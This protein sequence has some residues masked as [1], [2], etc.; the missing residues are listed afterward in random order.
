MEEGG[1]RIRPKQVPASLGH[2][3]QLAANMWVTVDEL[4][5]L[6]H[7]TPQAV[8]PTEA[9]TPESVIRQ[10]RKLYA[11]G[12]SV[13]QIKTILEES[14]ATPDQ[15]EAALAEVRQ[16]DRRKR[17]S[18]QRSL[19]LMGSAGA[20]F[21]LLLAGVAAVVVLRP[22]LRPSPA[23]LRPGAPANGQP[24]A[25]TAAPGFPNLNLPSVIPTDALATVAA[26]PTTGVQQGVGPE[27]SK[28]PVTPVSAARLFGGEPDYWSENNDFGRAW[29]MLAA[30]APLTIRVP[31][32]MSAG[33]MRINEGLEMISVVGPATLTN[34]NF[35]TISCEQ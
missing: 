7:Q 15:I 9:A 33:Y 32:N 23:T 8:Q 19:W 22:E 26:Q 3:G 29:V 16:L 30:S 2:R 35:V 21:F 20:M 34:V 25:A 10:A 4:R 12:N 24:P 14:K 18:N 1:S 6:A 28:C 13:R 11:L 5:A 27:A 31:A 17:E